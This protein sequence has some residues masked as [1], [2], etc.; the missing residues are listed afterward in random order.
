MKR[1]LWRERARLLLG[2]R[3]VGVRILACNDLDLLTR[4]DLTTGERRDYKTRQSWHHGSV[5]SDE[6]AKGRGVSFDQL[7]DFGMVSNTDRSL[8][9]APVS[10]ENTI[11]P[12]N[13]KEGVENWVAISQQKGAIARNLPSPERA[14]HPFPEL[15]VSI[16]IVA[17]L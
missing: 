1:T 11:A 9:Q 3:V 14:T 6:V 7:L 13:V 10:Q 12:K 16:F 15:L 8:L 4:D 5:A 2:R 17:F